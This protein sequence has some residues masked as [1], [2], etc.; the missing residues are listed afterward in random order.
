MRPIQKQKADDEAD[1]VED[2]VGPAL[3]EMGQDHH[4]DVAPLAEGVGEAAK[5]QHGHEIAREFIGDVEGAVQKAPEDDLADGD[6]EGDGHHDSRYPA[7]ESGKIVDQ[8][9]YLFHVSSMPVSV[10]EAPMNRDHGTR[11]SGVPAIAFMSNLQLLAADLLHELRVDLLGVGRRR[12]QPLGADASVI[13][14]RSATSSWRG[15]RSRCRSCC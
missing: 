1:H 3:E 15:Q 7:A 2:D 14:S 11:P 12:L 4:P 5:G 6:D 9:D 13:F 10:D 8:I